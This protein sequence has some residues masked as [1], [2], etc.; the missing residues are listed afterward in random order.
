MMRG[1]Q[2]KGR[3]RGGQGG[4]GGG[5]RGVVSVTRPVILQ[6]EGERIAATPVASR[7]CGTH[8]TREA[9]QTGLMLANISFV[10]DVGVFS[11]TR[12]LHIQRQMFPRTRAGG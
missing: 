4:E 1:G 3:W 12:S 2:P 10:R 8:S 6:Q 11:L 9:E 5:K 7:S